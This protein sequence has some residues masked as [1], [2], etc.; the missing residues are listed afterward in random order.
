MIAKKQLTQL[1]TLKD[2]VSLLTRQWEGDIGAN[3]PGYTELLAHVEELKGRF[4][5]KLAAGKKLLQCKIRLSILKRWFC[6][7][8]K[9]FI[10]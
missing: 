6:L 5:N 4:M 10:P 9:K 8:V 3:L 7:R 2:K 1:S